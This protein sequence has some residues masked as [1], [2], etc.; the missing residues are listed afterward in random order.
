MDHAINLKIQEVK[1]LIVEQTCKSHDKYL[2]FHTS[3]QNT[4]PQYISTV[5]NFVTEM[6]DFFQTGQFV[7]DV[8]DIIIQ[9]LTDALGA[10]SLHIS[11]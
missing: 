7:R 4:V 1:D 6:L 3:S 9:V 10:Q 2:E 5:D 11:R 8:I